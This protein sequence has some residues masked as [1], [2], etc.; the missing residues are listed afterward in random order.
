MLCSLAPFRLKYGLILPPSFSRYAKIFSTKSLF[1]P[2]LGLFFCFSIISRISSCSS[3]IVT[4]LFVL[5]VIH[6]SL[7]GHAL[8]ALTG[9]INL[10]FPVDCTVIPFGH[11]KK[12]LSVLSVKLYQLNPSSSFVFLSGASSSIPIA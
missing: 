11:V 10:F 9:K 6:L 8:H 7:S 3:G 4:V 2:S 12:D 1:L 5:D